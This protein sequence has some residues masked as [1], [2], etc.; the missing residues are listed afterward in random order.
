MDSSRL[1]TTCEGARCEPQRPQRKARAGR[2]LGQFKE[3]REKGVQGVRR[4]PST[5]EVYRM[6][7]AFT[8]VACLDLVACDE[9][10]AVFGPW[11]LGWL[12][13]G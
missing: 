2:G 6:V 13:V 9:R 10:T 11:H 12:G 7:L 5:L 4:A 1:G 3:A 8:C